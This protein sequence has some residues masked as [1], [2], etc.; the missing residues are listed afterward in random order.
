MKGCVFYW[1]IKP[2]YVVP[3]QYSGKQIYLQYCLT[4]KTWEFGVQEG[5]E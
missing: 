3:L 1:V 4:K 2:A 5:A